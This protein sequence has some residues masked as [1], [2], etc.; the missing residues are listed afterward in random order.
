M[1][2]HTIDLTR[3]IV[4]L[5]DALELAAPGM[6]MHQTKTS[7]ISLRIADKL[8]FSRARKRDLIYASL[9][10]DIGA[11]SPEEKVELETLDPLLVEK[12]SRG[13]QI[14][15]S[16]VPLL[17]RSAAI[18][19]NHHVPWKSLREQDEPEGFDSNIHTSQIA[20]KSQSTGTITSSFSM[21]W[22]KS[23]FTNSEGTNLL[24]K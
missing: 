22:S 11:L 16:R 21:K 17:S 24:P 5:S 2:G 13:G 6:A 8:G 10:H 3:F 9:L 23:E 19:G 20:W 15:L 4:M 7:Y 12:H 1:D 18:V 14:V